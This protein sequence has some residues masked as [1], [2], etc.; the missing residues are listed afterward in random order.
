MCYVKLRYDDGRI[1][2]SLLITK[3]RL[4]PINLVKIPRLELCGAV[5]AVRLHE[6]VSKE[7]QYSV[8][9]VFFWC[10]SMTVLQYIRNTTSRSKTFVAN[11]LAVIQ[12][13]TSI[14]DWRHIEGRLNPAALASRGF[15]PSDNGLMQD[16]LEG[17][18]FLRT[19]HYPEELKEKNTIGDNS[20]I[21]LM[22]Q[23]AENSFLYNLI[24]FKARR[25]IMRYLIFYERFRKIEVA[26]DCLR[27]IEQAKINLFRHC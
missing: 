15:M 18:F 12:E 10:D 2:V 22:T 26:A 7:L 3:S 8:R 1:Q 17:A 11:R 6:I 25:V 14:D 5:L 23:A 24:E 19:D 27:L 13:L 9:Q 4:A 21:V 16:W 20:E